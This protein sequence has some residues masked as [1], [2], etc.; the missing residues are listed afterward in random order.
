MIIYV[1]RVEKKII[2]ILVVFAAAFGVQAATETVNG[3]TW[4]YGDYFEDDNAP[5]Q[6]V[7]IYGI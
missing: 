7:C 5:L 4:S 2:A 1:R 3:Y 6:G